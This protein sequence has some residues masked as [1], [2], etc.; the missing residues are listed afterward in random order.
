METLMQDGNRLG[1]CRNMSHYCSIFQF[2]KLEIQ[3][4]K[5][6]L[7][8]YENAQFFNVDKFKHFVV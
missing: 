8:L 5:R 3:I 6:E 1:L 7:C 2:L 4:C